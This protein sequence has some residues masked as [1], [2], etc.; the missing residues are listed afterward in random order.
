V[1]FRHRIKLPTLRDDS[2][3]AINKIG[4]RSRCINVS[5]F[6]S[7]YPCFNRRELR[8]YAARD[9]D[10]SGLTSW[11]DSLPKLPVFHNLTRL[12]I[13]EPL[14]FDPSA[15]AEVAPNLISLCVGEID[16]IERPASLSQFRQLEELG[17]SVKGTKPI[18]S[19]PR[20]IILLSLL[21]PEHHRAEPFFL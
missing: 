11:V 16:Q 10:E 5:F 4:V 17:L 12:L 21:F 8:I 9:L 19:Q 2:A 18:L 1:A 15:I 3:A 20:S 14:S 13:E 6:G 7:T